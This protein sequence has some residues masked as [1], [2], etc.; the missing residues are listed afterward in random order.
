MSNFSAEDEASL[1]SM[2]RQLLQSVK[3][4]LVSTPS[5]ECA[6]EI[7][8]HLEETDEHFHNY[9]LVKYLRHY[10]KSTLGSVI[11]EET[12]KCTL[13]QSQG[14]GSGYDTL[15]QHVTKRTRESKEYTDMMH[16]LKNVMMAVVETLLNKFEEDQVRN[17]EMLTKTLQEQHGPRYPDNCSDSDSSFNQSYTFMNQEQLQLIAEQ[18]DPSQPEEVR[19]EAMQ[20]LCSAPPSD[21]LKCECWNIL[22]KNLTLSLADPD[23]TF[24]EKILRFYAKTFS[25]S[26]LNMAREVYTSLAKHLELSFVSKEG[27]KASLSTGVEVTNPSVVRLLKKFRLLNDYQKEA[28]SFWIRH[29]EKY[30]EEIVESTLSLLSVTQDSGSGF[31][32]PVFFMA[33]IDTKAV[34]FKKWMHAYYSRTVVL[35]LLEKKYKSL[36]ISAVEQCFYYFESSQSR[37]DETCQ[38]TI[39]SQQHSGIKQKTFYTRRELHYLYFVHSLSLL[40]RLLIY[41]H[42]RKLFPVKLKNRKELVSLSD[43][44][45]LFTHIMLYCPNGPKRA[46]GTYTGSYAPSRLAMEALRMLC[47]CK[48]CAGECLYTGAVIETLLGPI[49]K[50]LKG[51]KV[52][53]NCDET[54]LTYIADILARIASIEGGL[55]LLLY[56]ERG[57]C[58]K[59]STI[60][61]HVIAQFSKKLLREEIPAL[62]ASEMLPVLKGSFIFVCRQM[63]HTCEGFQ[64]LIPYQLHECIAEA[65]KKT[66]LLSERTPT[67]V[68]GAAS[69]SSESNESQ[70]IMAWEESLLD[71]LL[72]FAAT[73][74]GLL[75]LQQTG[76]I[77]ECVTYMFSRFTKKL[78]VS[79]CEKFGY[80]VIVTQVAAVAPGALALQKSGF[81]QALVTDLWAVL[82]CGRDDVRIIH[83][84]PTPVDPIDRSCHKSFLALVNLLSS[85][86]AVYEL[87]GKQDLPSKDEYSLREVPTCIPDILDRLIIVN[88]DAKIN[89]LFN[90]EQS[91][92]FGLRLLSILCCNLD[93]LLLLESQYKVCE[94]L[95]NAQKENVTESSTGFGNVIVDALSVE[96][97][98]LLIQMNVIGG[99][100]ERI[101]PPRALL[102]SNDPYPW[103]M[104][105]SY[106]LP[107][108]Y[109]LETPLKQAIKQDN[110]LYKFLSSKNTVT[111]TSWLENCQRLFC[112]T[113]KSKS[114]ELNTASVYLREFLASLDLQD[115][116]PH[117][118][119]HQECQLF[120][121]FAF[122]CIH[123][124]AL[125][126]SVPRILTKIMAALASYSHAQDIYLT[127]YLDNLLIKV[128]L[129]ELLALHIQQRAH[130]LVHHGW[131]ITLKKCSPIPSQVQVF[132]G[133]RFK[134]FLVEEKIHGCSRSSGFCAGGSTLCSVIHESAS[135]KH[136]QEVVQETRATHPLDDSLT[137]GQGGSSI[138]SALDTIQMDAPGEELVVPISKTFVAYPYRAEADFDVAKL[139]GQSSLF[140][141]EL[142]KVISHATG[143]YGELL[144]KYVSH[145]LEN[146]S[147]CY[148]SQ[149]EHKDADLQNHTLSAV[150]HLGVKMVIR[151][152]RHLNLLTGNSEH[153]FIQVLKQCKIFLRHQQ[154]VPN[155]TLEYLQGSYSGHDWFAS[156]IF[157]IMS[158]DS[159]KTLTFLLKF[160]SLLVSAYLWLPRLHI[161]KHLP[162][163]IAQS[164]IH[165][166]YFCTAHYIE[167]LMKAEVPLVFSAFRMS[168]FT[169][170]QICQHW[171]NQCF[172]NYLDWEEICH[173][174]AVC[175]I[176]GADYQVYLCIAIFKHLQQEILQHT[177][178]QDLQVFLKEEAIHGFLVGNYLE[179]MESLE[180]IYRPIVLKEMRNFAAQ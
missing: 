180:Q 168:G 25:S 106:P 51:K 36:I 162:A 42:G 101:L 38:A 169:P 31:L 99:P 176:L 15:V 108:C 40:G 122:T 47:D 179:Y 24:T 79:R 74:K 48:E 63:Y 174:I 83:P 89:S 1:Q 156:S 144:D 107:K 10:I 20:T 75:L 95:L 133:M 160:S 59:D 164:G 54:T 128:P 129:E 55:S 9:E 105:S 19:N 171:L 53:M 140:D 45:V 90:Y 71:N 13:A 77:N 161:S 139:N 41:K 69:I 154:V 116:Y 170:S 33:L 97:N 18:L 96:R 148:F 64:V 177:Q 110:D 127:Q 72:N 138:E 145:Y 146:T 14:E 86:S 163:S 132:L 62:S 78:Q 124:L 141:S 109:I 65:W 173:Y 26:P 8:L 88:S 143:V 118:Y 73:P 94:M 29:P 28:P 87:L 121:H 52:H 68:A 115:S 84:K 159:E 152:G 142:E 158:G 175:T 114:D 34:W 81:I 104:F 125:V 5:A 23:S 92:I 82:E 4:R 93:T 112:K 30:M 76:A 58:T 98:H 157:L 120:L 91:H 61:A 126:K 167:M 135:E 166:I 123:Y 131:K 32:D 16:S 17:R 137:A 103:P 66:I 37:V 117:V 49:Q 43:L 111:K 100:H 50:L 172:W 46:L 27:Q 147:N 11:D 7:L 130:I 119:I 134:M 44:V 2:V 3:D 155:S 60:G 70:G 85:F 67:P 102:Q 21:V 136:P 149:L 178:T 12:E 57:D 6:E 153:D 56:G 39:S 150:Q 35:R 165:P 151:Y 22:Q 80:G 113:I